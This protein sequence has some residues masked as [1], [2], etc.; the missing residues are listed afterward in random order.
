MLSQEITM[1]ALIFFGLLGDEGFKWMAFCSG[2][3]TEPQNGAGEISLSLSKVK[4]IEN[5]LV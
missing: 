3:Y 4:P 2:T 1:C 5:P